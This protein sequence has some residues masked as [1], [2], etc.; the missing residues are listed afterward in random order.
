M[1]TQIKVYSHYCHFCRV[2]KYFNKIFHL[3]GSF[4][5]FL[6]IVHSN[7][8]VKPVFSIWAIFHVRY[9]DPLLSTERTSLICRLI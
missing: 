8:A 5:W 7:S 6:S 3:D 9:Q 2:L 4:K 1:I